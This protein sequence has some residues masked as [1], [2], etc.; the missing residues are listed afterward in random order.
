[1]IVFIEAAFV[2]S[3][4]FSNYWQDQSTAEYYMFTSDFGTLRLKRRDSYPQTYAYVQGGTLFFGYGNVPDTKWLDE[5][6]SAA[7][8]NVFCGEEFL[9]GTAD[10]LG[11]KVSIQRDAVSTVPLFVGAQDDRLVLSNKYERVCGLLRAED[12]YPNLQTLVEHLLGDHSYERTLVK[13]ITALSNRMRL[14]WNASGYY[15]AHHPGTY[16]QDDGESNPAEFRA[17]LDMVIASYWER[18]AQTNPMGLELS[19]GMDSSAVAAFLVQTHRP[20]LAGTVVYPGDTGE[21]QKDKL[22]DLRSSLSIVSTQFPADPAT[23]HPMSQR[24]KQSQPFYHREELYGASF[25]CLARHM[26][27]QGVTAV[28]RGIGGDELCEN[29]PDRLVIGYETPSVTHA[30]RYEGLPRVFTP[31]MDTYAQAVLAQ[32]DTTQ[33]QP[34]TSSTAAAAAASGN[35]LYLDY[36]IWPVAP[37][38]EPNLYRYAQNLAPKYRMY[39]NILR[40]YA[41]AYGVPRSISHPETTEGFSDFLARSLPYMKDQ[42]NQYMHASV[43]KKAG[44]LSPQHIQAAWHSNDN[45]EQFALYQILVAEMNLQRLGH[46]DVSVAGS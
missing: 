27:A 42:F 38:T 11:Q 4:H 12:F 39:K 40:A 5:P 1:M 43:L 41:A 21:R 14:A 17:R 29:I 37:L 23:E 19:G 13:E 7:S 8:M 35:N 18:Y 32:R 6:L 25:S 33:S 22:Q 26:Y 10:C 44:L 34:F 16:G 24:Y 3:A 9:F 15:L 45:A 28:I 31:A 2:R 46:V 30:R 20:F 36:D